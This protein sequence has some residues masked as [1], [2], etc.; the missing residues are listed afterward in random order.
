MNQLRLS[1]C[2]VECEPLRFTPAGVAI[3]QGKL[4]HESTQLDAGHDRQVRLSIAARFAGPLAEQISKESL[5]CALQVK[6][7]LAPKR[8]FRDGTSSASLVFHVV[9]YQINKTAT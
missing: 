5:G 6:G 3:C 8:V 4:E 1:A 2:L 9:A 7:F